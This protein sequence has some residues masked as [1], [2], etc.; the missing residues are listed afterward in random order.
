MV[1][2]ARP[3]AT[4]AVTLALGLAGYVAPAEAGS[5]EYPMFSQQM[6]RSFLVCQTAESES[7]CGTWPRPGDQ[8][9]KAGYAVGKKEQRIEFSSKPCDSGRTV[10]VCQ[11]SSGSQIHFYEGSLEQLASGCR[12]M[13]GQFKTVEALTKEKTEA[14]AVLRLLNRSTE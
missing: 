5:C 6:A 7:Q 13:Y 10:A 2:I 9:L 11:L 3:T 8:P 1:R 14:D 12:R 4:S